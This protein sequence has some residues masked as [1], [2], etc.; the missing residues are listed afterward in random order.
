MPQI[1]VIVAV[2]KVENYLAQCIES[3]LHQTVS[4]LELI[5]VDDGSPDNSGKICDDYARKDTRVRVLHKPNGG[6]T[7]ARK[8]GLAMAT[9][10]YV[11]FVDSDDF[12]EPDMYEKMLDACLTQGAELVLCGYRTDC[13]QRSE[14]G[15]NGLPSGVYRGEQLD[16][17]RANAVYYLKNNKTGING[18]MW[19]KL[20]VREKI[21]DAFLNQDELL[22]V[23][24]DM[25]FSCRALLDAACVV[26]QN[27]NHGYHYRVHEGS[28]ISTPNANYFRDLFLLDKSLR[29]VM[30]PYGD[31]TF[32]CGLA[33]YFVYSFS[34]GIY[35]FM[36]RN[37][38]CSL[39][40][41]YRKLRQLTQEDTVRRWLADLQKQALSPQAYAPVRYLG[42]KKPLG[43]VLYYYCYTIGRKMRSVLCR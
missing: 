21:L 11:S 32:A 37:N 8:A 5:L 12:L 26:I 31:A 1:S 6:H 38:A 2:Y 22:R 15:E 36:G 16:F 20:F 3:I 10:T 34:D 42:Q 39:P 4:N 17:L 28:I 7:S 41:K 33:M 24:E 40:E 43:F 30:G 14:P 18:A 25:L 19:N 29:D 13:G 23:G 9:G 35:R 27:E